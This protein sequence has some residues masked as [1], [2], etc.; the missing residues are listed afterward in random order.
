MFAR[1]FRKGKFNKRRFNRNFLNEDHKIN[2]GRSNFVKIDKSKIKCFN[3]SELCHFVSEWKKPR[4]LGKGKALMTT[5]KDWA[6]S[7]SS[8]D[9]IDYDNIPLMAISSEKERSTKSSK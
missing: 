7:S 8:E 9:E 3:C 6:D 5:Q 2:R 1:R 4:N